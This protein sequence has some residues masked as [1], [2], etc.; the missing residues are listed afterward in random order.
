VPCTS[1]TR[2]VLQRG[3]ACALPDVLPMCLQICEIDF[4]APFDFA[5]PFHLSL[6]Q[7]HT[8]T[9]SLSPRPSGSSLSS[10]Q[11]P[12][13][14][15]TTFFGLMPPSTSPF[16]CWPS[17]LTACFG[18]SNTRVRVSSTHM[19]VSITRVGVSNPGV[20]VYNAGSGVSSTRVCVS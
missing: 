15:G 9:L 1:A 5:L 13:E 11:L 16:R 10:W 17:H 20:G 4:A 12:S 19:G 18:V 8:L 6:S 2:C 7:T 3:K 14:E